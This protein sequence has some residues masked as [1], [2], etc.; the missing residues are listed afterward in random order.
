MCK[1][2]RACSYF[3]CYSANTER[4]SIFREENAENRFRLCSLHEQRYFTMFTP[5]RA[6]YELAFNNSL[7]YCRF[8]FFLNLFT[9]Q[10]GP[11]C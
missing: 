4:D 5:K 6:K 10:E 3:A 8:V 1:N 9:E 11:M 2:L 7:N